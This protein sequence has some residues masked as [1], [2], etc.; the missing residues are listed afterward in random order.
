MVD[1]MASKMAE[2]TKKCWNKSTKVSI[3]DESRNIL[4]KNPNKELDI[5]F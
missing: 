1:K 5:Y 2:K 4:V 3:N